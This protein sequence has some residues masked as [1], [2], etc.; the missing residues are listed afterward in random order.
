[1][2]KIK[3][4][5]QKGS[6]R[7]IVFKEGEVFYAVG[8]EFN[9]IVEGLTKESALFLLFDAMKGYVESAKKASLRPNVLNQVS[10]KEYEDLWDKL[11]SN[12]SIPSP[13]Q[14]YTFGT[15]LV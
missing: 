5:I 15:Q 2:K 7:Y 3:N 4:S 11:N 6:V 9:I 14:V 12:E 10:E 8:L 13:Y 1:M